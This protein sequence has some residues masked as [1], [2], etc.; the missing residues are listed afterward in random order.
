M[1]GICSD[2]QPTRSEV[3]GSSRTVIIRRDFCLLLG[4]TVVAVGF[5][6]NR[7]LA[8][9]APLKA[10]MVEH[11]LVDCPQEH[12]VIEVDSDGVEQARSYRV[13]R[14]TCEIRGRVVTLD[15][16]SLVMPICTPNE[17][18]YLPAER[19]FIDRFTAI[20]EQ[21]SAEGLAPQERCTLIDFF[22]WEVELRF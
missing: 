15:D 14:H 18:P 7:S 19:E 21:W 6:L 10:V 8:G 16:A 3:T 9:V 20:L 11:I 1:K 13:G 17:P 5:G 12:C 4:A 2:L 22:A